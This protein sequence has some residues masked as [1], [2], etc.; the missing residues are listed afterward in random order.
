MPDQ[1]STLCG[2]QERMRVWGNLVTLQLL[3]EGLVVSQ[4]SFGP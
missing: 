4:T 3:E 1:N 2:S